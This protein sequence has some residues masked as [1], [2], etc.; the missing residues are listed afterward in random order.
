MAEM[1]APAGSLLT[2]PP[3]RPEYVRD[4]VAGRDIGVV[5]APLTIWQRLAN[6]GWLRKALILLVIAA[7]WQIYA[8][9]LNNPLLVPTFFSTLEAFKDGFASGEIPEKVVNSVQLL[10]KGYAL[11]LGLAMLFT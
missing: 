11:G 4:T 6:Q 8:Y 10:L 2:F 3:L 5:Q 9:N 1:R 7:A